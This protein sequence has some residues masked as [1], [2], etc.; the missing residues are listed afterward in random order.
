MSGKKPLFAF[1]GTPDVAVKVLER[2]EAHGLMPAL[3][4][5]APDKPRGRG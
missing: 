2:L 3:V 1:F 5:T 4:I